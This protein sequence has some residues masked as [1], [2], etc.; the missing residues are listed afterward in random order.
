M[1]K[2]TPS[3]Q[4]KNKD[5]SGMNYLIKD[6]V[7]NQQLF[8]Y[9]A[10][11]QS[12]SSNKSMN[13][14]DEFKL[15]NKNSHLKHNKKL[16]T[17]HKST[18]SFS[19]PI[20]FSSYLNLNERKKES[21]DQSFFINVN[22][23]SFT[24]I[25]PKTKME[26]MNAIS[27]NHSKGRNNQNLAQFLNVQIE[28]KN[29][30]PENKSEGKSVDTQ[31]LFQTPQSKKRLYTVE[32]VFSISNDSSSINETM[33]FK[34]TNTNSDKKGKNMNMKFHRNDKIQNVMIF[35]FNKYQI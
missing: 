33:C 16:E 10:I 34:F 26:E 27:S 2:E 13:N 23:M 3:T 18:K 14:L 35:I 30:P 28:N 1:F 20:H 5:S 24:E 6:S 17:N 31:A 7:Y 9:K 29:S 25:N 8:S 32:E 22:E 15:F 4:E 12:R 21:P 19:K 11:K